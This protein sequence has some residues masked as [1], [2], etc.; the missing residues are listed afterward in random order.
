[1]QLSFVCMKISIYWK[2]KMMNRGTTID[3]LQ[4]RKLRSAF[5][6]YNMM[7]T[8]NM[9]HIAKQKIKGFLEKNAI[10]YQ[11]KTNIRRV[12]H[13]MHMIAKRIRA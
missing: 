9:Q 11:L 7:I 1:M 10:I 5:S 3:E 4:R 13:L 2:K 12:S 6:S 8:D